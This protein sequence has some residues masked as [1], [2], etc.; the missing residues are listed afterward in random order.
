MVSNNMHLKLNVHARDFCTKT[1][2]V[3]LLLL[4]TLNNTQLNII[5][6]MTSIM[7]V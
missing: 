5:M 3:N 2:H 1:A 4:Y 7:Y 6:Q